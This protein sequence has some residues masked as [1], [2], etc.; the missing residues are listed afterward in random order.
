MTVAS[1][2]VIGS[3]TPPAGSANATLSTSGLTP[4]SGSG[5]PRAISSVSFASRPCALAA[6]AKLPA[7]RSAAAICGGALAAQLGA[8]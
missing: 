2:V 5:E 7:D 8:P 1:L 6:A 4:M 3:L